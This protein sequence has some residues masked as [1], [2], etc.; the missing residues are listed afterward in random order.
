MSENLGVD[1]YK[2]HISKLSLHQSLVKP[3]F[4]YCD[5]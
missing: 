3:K 4:I 1:I 2:E 5:F